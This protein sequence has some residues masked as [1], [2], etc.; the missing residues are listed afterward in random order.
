M[1]GV[2]CEEQV[3]Q[4]STPVDP[5]EVALRSSAIICVVFDGRL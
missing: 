1:S 4:T 3:H 5:V 2:M